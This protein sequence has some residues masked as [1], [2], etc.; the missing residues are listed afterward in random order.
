MCKDVHCI[1]YES[2]FIHTCMYM[3]MQWQVQG[4]RTLITPLYPPPLLTFSPP[5]SHDAVWICH[6]HVA[7]FNCKN[8]CKEVHHTVT[9]SYP[10]TTIFHLSRDTVI[11]RNGSGV[12]T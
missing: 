2:I 6:C 12:R 1:D 10:D 3:Y 11:M 4:C 7:V 5:D 9:Q 8:N